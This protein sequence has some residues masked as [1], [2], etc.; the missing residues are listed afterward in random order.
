M[1]TQSQV[2]FQEEIR[3]KNAFFSVKMCDPLQLK[4]EAFLE[5]PQYAFFEKKKI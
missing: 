3:K 5:C 1:G 2:L 4:L